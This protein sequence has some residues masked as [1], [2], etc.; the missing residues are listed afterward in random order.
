MKKLQRRAMMKRVTV[1]PSK[2]ASMVGFAGGLLFV[3]VGIALVIPTF[4]GFGII[5]T[6]F[7]GAITVVNGINAFSDRT[8]ATREILIEEDSDLSQKPPQDKDPAQR[9]EQ[10]RDLYERRLITQEEYEKRRAEII[11]QL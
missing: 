11:D 2:G 7:A 4:G 6:L 10:L 5:W 8:V 3:L 1:K 9:L